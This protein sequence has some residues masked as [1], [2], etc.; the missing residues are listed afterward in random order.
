MNKIRFYD[1]KYTGNF[2]KI[3]RNQ[4]LKISLKQNV[5]KI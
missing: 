3:K 1:L 2:I 4:C 5:I